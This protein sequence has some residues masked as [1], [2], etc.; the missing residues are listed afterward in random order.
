MGYVFADGINIDEFIDNPGKDYV[1]WTKLAKQILRKRELYILKTRLQRVRHIINQ[2]ILASHVHYN[3]CPTMIRKIFRDLGNEINKWDGIR[4]YLSYNTRTQFPNFRKYFDWC[5]KN[6]SMQ[7]AKVFGDIFWRRV[8]DDLSRFVWHG[9]TDARIARLNEMTIL[10]NLFN[11][12]VKYKH[13]NRIQPLMLDSTIKHSKRMQRFLYHLDHSS[14]A[15]KKIRQLRHGQ[16]IS[17]IS[18]TLSALM[19]E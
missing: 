12:T 2:N 19:D 9:A 17:S 18:G 1:N 13:C 16:V 6:W 8:C 11:G 3:L 4:S 5:L 15:P 10:K 14:F 7:K